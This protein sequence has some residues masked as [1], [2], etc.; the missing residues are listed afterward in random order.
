MVEDIPALGLA[1]KKKTRVKRGRKNAA[2]TKLVVTATAKDRDHTIEIG[3]LFAV[4]IV[5]V[6]FFG[7]ARNIHS[8]PEPFPNNLGLMGSN[9]NV[10]HPL[11]LEDDL[12]S[13]SSNQD[14]AAA[15]PAVVVTNSDIHIPAAQ[16]P[17]SIRN[18]DGNFETIIHP[19]DGH[20]EMDVPKFWSRPV[21]N[22]GLMSRETAM[23]I[24]SC[25]EPDT[26]GNH[27]RGE[28]C[29]KHQRTIFVGIASYRDFECRTTVESI[30]LRA[31]YPERIRVGVV[32]QIVDG[33]DP[34]CDAPV[35]PCSEKPN[36]ALCKYKDQVDV[37]QMEAE[38][39]VGPVFARHIGYRLYRGEYYATQSD[40]HVTFTTG[41]D[42]DIIE[43]MEGTGNEMTVLTTYLTDIQG[44]IDEK[45]GNSLRRTRPI[46]CNTI[47]EGGPQGLHL[48]H[49]SQPEGPPR[50]QGMPQLEPWWAA[51][52]S[53]SRG[54]F[55][56]NVPYDPLQPMIFQG[57][58]MSIG[59]RGF[60]VGYDFYAPERS[61]C[62]HHYAIGKN[63]KKRNKVKHFWE[64]GERY[65]GVG[66]RAMSRLLGIV[67]MNPEKD[68]KEWDHTEEDIYGIGGV[69]SPELFYE[70]FG[71][72]VKKKTIEAHL[73]RFVDWG[74]KM[75]KAFQKHLR[76][77]GMGIDYSKINFKF[78][79]PEKK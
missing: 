73:C 23:K 27:A 5:C 7:L 42:M 66:K 79:D 32:D 18:E 77:D 2:S 59:I 57:E 11:E 24:G 31:K 35:Y 46:M 16:W 63:A 58:E 67:R 3:A 72:D 70:T 13:R 68:P 37:Y 41:W 50:V 55:I 15:Q 10:A 40:A 1:K 74:G 29:A 20:T 43:Q 69:R 51:G 22:N 28:N 26:D 39:S 48:R 33:E 44:S 53:F 47:Y 78:K 45:T 54:H 14:D 65:P 19:A 4:G 60:T 76:K 71:I 62:F 49:A 8:L 52:Y 34:V 21:H 75:H 36:Q 64:N 30:F 38:L 17:V 9:I 61:V 12:S 6:Y 25:V 56:V